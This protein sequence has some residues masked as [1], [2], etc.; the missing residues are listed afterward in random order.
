MMMW[1][2]FLSFLKMC[3]SNK[4][5][6]K[7][8]VEIIVFSR[9]GTFAVFVEQSHFNLFS[10]LFI[11]IYFKTA[12]VNSCARPRIYS[13]NACADGASVTGKKSMAVFCAAIPL[14]F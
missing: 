1:W 3:V 7:R 8:L 12:P 11:F 13:S 5:K 6:L 10:T 9:V 2:C 14:T 4:L